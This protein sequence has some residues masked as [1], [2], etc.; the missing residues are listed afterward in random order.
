MHLRPLRP[1]GELRRI[2]STYVALTCAKAIRMP[3]PHYW[4]NLHFTM[5]WEPDAPRAERSVI[6]SAVKVAIT[7]FDGHMG[8][9]V[10]NNSEGSAA[11]DLP[12]A[13]I[14]ADFAKSSY[15]TAWLPPQSEVFKNI[16]TYLSLN[17]MAKKITA[18][19]AEKTRMAHA[20]RLR[21]EV[22]ES[23][24][25]NPN[26]P[27]ELKRKEELEK[28]LREKNRFFDKAKP[29]KSGPAVITAIKV[30]RQTNLWNRYEA[31][32]EEISRDIAGG[33]K[34]ALTTGKFGSS[35]R[36]RLQLT[37]SSGGYPSSTVRSAKCS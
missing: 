29:P 7:Q 23:L 37:S 31:R 9:E 27:L 3:M 21:G 18:P 16:S 13:E 28:T 24:K 10:V 12:I 34:P 22:E 25:A 36:E 8:R 14:I 6:A 19:K 2:S 30:V 17:L 5:G 32:K 26:D 15:E 4:D 1:A 33:E 20:E 11:V 35:E